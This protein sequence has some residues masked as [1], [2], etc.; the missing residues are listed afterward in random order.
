LRD[1][2]GTHFGIFDFV[3]IDSEALGVDR[4]LATVTSQRGPIFDLPIYEEVMRFAT[5]CCRSAFPGADVLISDSST[6]MRR[7]TVSSGALSK[8]PRRRP[9]RVPAGAAA[10]QPR[11]DGQSPGWRI[12]GVA[13]LRRKPAD[14]PKKRAAV[15]V[16]RSTLFNAEWYLANYP[17]VAASG[18]D[19]V[20]HYLEFGWHEGRNPSPDFSTKAYLKAN[21]DVAEQGTNPLVHYLEHGRIEGRKAPRVKGRTSS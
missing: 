14:R 1:S 17:D 3:D 13:K 8:G 20:L 19:P 6:F 4:L 12:P 7:P 9:M 16:A 18:A 2:L 15:L 10:V 11:L 21:G 5:I